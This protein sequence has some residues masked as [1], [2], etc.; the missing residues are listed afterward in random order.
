MVGVVIHRGNADYGHYTSIIDVNRNDPN[1]NREKVENELWLNFDDSS[2]S[3]FDMKNFEDE[4][5]GKT[6]EMNQYR[7]FVH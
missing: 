2:V 1:K 7:G 4:C 6:M 5:F 3:S